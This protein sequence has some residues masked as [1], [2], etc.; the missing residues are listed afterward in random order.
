MNGLFFAGNVDGLVDMLF[1][2]I[3]E[4]GD[5]PSVLEA[6]LWKRL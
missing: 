5:T 3:T 2:L 1:K 6:I 4:L